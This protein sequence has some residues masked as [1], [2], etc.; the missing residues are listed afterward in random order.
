MNIGARGIEAIARSP[1]TEGN[2]WVGKK[3][4]SSESRRQ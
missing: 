3:S 2:Y 4:T 1:K